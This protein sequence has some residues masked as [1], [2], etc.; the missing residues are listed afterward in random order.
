MND[1]SSKAMT[2]QVIRRAPIDARKLTLAR[3]FRREPTRAEAAAWQ[4]LRNRGLLGL[5]FRRQQV[6]EGFVVDFYCAS[7]RL[8]LELDG[9]VHQDPAQREYDAIRGEVLEG[10]GM[11]VLRIANDPIDE[12]SLRERLAPYVAERVSLR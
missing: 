3:R 9:G 10:L 2:P 6:I 7:L 1:P 12:G 11:R 8:V 5:K 4:L